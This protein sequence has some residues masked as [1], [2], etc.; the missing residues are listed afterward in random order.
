MI[1]YKDM[2]FCS[3][4][5]ANDECFRQ[6]TQAHMDAANKW[7]EGMDGPPPVAFS[8][9]SIDCRAFIEKTC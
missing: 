2:T 1:C 6:F 5:C 4:K 7:W 3:A 9:F 8:E